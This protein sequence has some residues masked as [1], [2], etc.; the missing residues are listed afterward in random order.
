MKRRDF[1]TK[2]SLGG[3]ATASA[4]ATPALAQERIEIAMVSTWPRDFPGL[5]TGAQRFAQSVTDATDGRMQVTYYAAGERVGAFDSFDEVASGNA[6]MY[7]A[8]DYYWKGKHPAWAYFTTVPFGLTNTEID[9]W[10]KWMGGQELH[11]ELAG[12]FDL[13]CLPCGN[14]GTQWGGWFNK[15]INSV[16]DLKGLKMRTPGLGG[17]VL[18]KL[19]VSPVSLPGGQIYENLISGALDAAEWVGPWNDEAMK[20]YEAARYYYYPGIHEPGAQLSVG[21]NASFWGGL[22][23]SDQLLLKHLTASENANMMAEYNAKNGEALVRLQQDH[24]VE[25]REFSD[26]LYL[27]FGRATDE[28]FAEVTGHSE[29]AQ[30]VHDSFLNARK[31]VGDYLV[32]NDVAYINKRSKVLGKQ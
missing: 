1:I 7:H 28:V 3:I 24:G 20:F 29:L 10:M 5:G 31:T 19:G 22:K 30:R 14:T 25:I 27:A 12:Q 15:A 17:D 23:E 2:A 11:D 4:L 26:E 13:K 9:S 18:A 6:Q 21:M 32:L 16:D 8:A